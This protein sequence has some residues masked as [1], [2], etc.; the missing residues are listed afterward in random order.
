MGPLLHPLD[1]DLELLASDLPGCLDPVE[2]TDSG[3]TW[4]EGSGVQRR[5]G[6]RGHP[7]VVAACD[8]VGK[9]E[10]AVVRDLRLRPLTDSVETGQVD[11][12]EVQAP[13][14]AVEL[15]Q[16]RHVRSGHVVVVET[17]HDV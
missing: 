10:S 7:G 16:C 13:V 11:L 4:C 15:E 6:V 17:L 1:A 2:D 9:H 3:V 5:A 8:V 14:R 12:G